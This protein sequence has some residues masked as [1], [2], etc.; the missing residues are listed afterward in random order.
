MEGYGAEL[1]GQ[2]SHN[3]NQTENE[4]LVLDVARHNRLVNH[5]DI[6]RTG[7]TVEHGH[8]VQ[9]KAGRHGT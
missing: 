7:G 4:D 5:R 8:A 6:Q 3:E 2:T 1:E 9:Q